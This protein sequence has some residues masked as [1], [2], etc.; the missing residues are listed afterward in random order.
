MGC[1]KVEMIIYVKHLAQCLKHNT[2]KNY[3]NNYCFCCYCYY[4]YNSSILGSL[5]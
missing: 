4:Y 1:V 5:W 2:F 3:Q